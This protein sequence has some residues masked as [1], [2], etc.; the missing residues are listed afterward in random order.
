ME[1]IIDHFEEYYRWYIIGAIGV[2]SV[3]VIF[4]KQAVPALMYA[5]ELAI[6]AEL[7]HGF[8]H[9]VSPNEICLAHFPRAHARFDNKI[10]HGDCLDLGRAQERRRLHLLPDQEPR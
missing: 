2:L 10:P 8:V 4:R 5:V 3:L 1:P 6:Y 9:I 7:M